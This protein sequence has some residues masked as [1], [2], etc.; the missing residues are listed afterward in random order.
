MTGL[1]NGH[2]QKCTRTQGT[3]LI[4]ILIAPLDWYLCYDLSYW[5]FDA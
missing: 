2:Y 3:K 4:Y 1:S 5:Q